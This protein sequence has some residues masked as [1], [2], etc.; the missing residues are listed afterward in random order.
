MSDQVCKAKN[1]YI[2][3][4]LFNN[5]SYL[6]SLSYKGIPI[7]YDSEPDISILENK[8]LIRQSSIKQRIFLEYTVYYEYE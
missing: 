3:W 6:K 8:I 4:N 1:C 5:W 7:Y 2:S